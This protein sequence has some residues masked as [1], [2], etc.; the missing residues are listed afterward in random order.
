MKKLL[1]LCVAV[2]AVSDMTAIAVAVSPATVSGTYTYLVSSICPPVSTTD[3]GSVGIATGT[4]ALNSGTAI[5][6]EIG[7]IGAGLT[8]GQPALHGPTKSSTTYSTTATTFT[9][10]SVTFQ[11]TYSNPV[12]GIYQSVYL[13]GITQDNTGRS[14][15]STVSLTRQ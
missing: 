14:C 7:S 6:G 13:I 4:L 1:L 10:G 12:G 9:L 8:I 2:A 3:A 15:A 5:Q 11:A